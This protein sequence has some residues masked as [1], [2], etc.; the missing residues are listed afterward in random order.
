[1]EQMD[2]R[3]FVKLAGAG[4]ALA[5]ASAAG[6]PL[7]AHVL[8]NNAGVLRFSASAG[9]PAKPLASYATHLVEGTVDLGTGTGL[10]TSRVVAGHPGEPSLIGL[11]G[12]AR[13]ISIT[14]VE[15]D[16]QRYRL[17]GVIEDRS[18]LQRGESPMVEILVD[19]AR[20]LVHVPF[21]GH[22][23]ALPLA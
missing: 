21:L 9:V 4:S 14:N 18:Q 16:G 6:V 8:S 20:K 13:V 22:P 2:R 19:R 5:A 11:P 7:A 17:Q 15:P 23:S 10:V 1:M 3:N 12:L